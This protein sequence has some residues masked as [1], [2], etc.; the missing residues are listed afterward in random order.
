MK[1]IILNGT[2]AMVI[3][4]PLPAVERGGVLVRT[5]FSLISTGTEIASLLPPPPSQVSPSQKVQEAAGLALL[6]L[7]K[8]ARNPAKAAQRVGNILGRRVQRLIPRKPSEQSIQV[9]AVEWRRANAKALT[10]HGQGLCLHSDSS[11]FLYQAFST[12]LP[13]PEGCGVVV[14]LTG[15]LTGGPIALGLLAGTDGPWLGTITLDEGQLDERLAF[16]P[17]GQPSVTLVF[18]NAG[19]GRAVQLD[20][21]RIDITLPPP[22]AGPQSEMDQQGWAVGYSLVGEIIAVGEGVR[23]LVIGDM[24]AC[25]GANKANHAEYVAVKRNMACR[26]P[27]GCDPRWA[28]TTTVGAIALQGVRRATPQIGERIAVIGLGLIG[29]LCAQMLR[30]AGSVVIGMDLDP[31][32]IS[33]AKALGLDAGTSDPD[34]FRQIIRDLTGGLGVDRVLVAAATKSN[35]VLNLAMEV[36]RSKGTIVIVGDIGLAVDR[37]HFYRKE[38][39]LLMSTSY[40]PGRY[41]PAYEEDGIDYPAPYVRWTMN[42]N[43]A[44]YMDL[45]S[46]NRI[47]VEPLIDSEA[48]ISQAPELYKSLVEG[49]QRPLGV[50]ISYPASSETARAAVITLKGAR[51]SKADQIN[52]VLVGAGAFGISMLVP[53]LARQPD[54]FCLRGIVSADAVRGGNFARANRLEIVASDL[55]QTLEDPSIHCAIIA[56]R[57]DRHAAQVITALEAGR[58]VF[59]EKPLALTWQELDAVVQA[60]AKAEHPPVVMVGFNRRFSPAVQR[61]K[62]ELAERR[63][64]LMI[65]YRVNAGYIPKDNWVQGREGG[66]RNLGE[67]CHM[68]DVFRCLTGAPVTSIHATAIAPDA[69]AYL[70]TDNFTATLAYED[71]SVCT[72]TY[73][74]LGPKTGLPK[75]RVEVYCDGKA[76]VID[77]F[78]TLWAAGTDSPLWQSEEADKGHAEEIARFGDAIATGSDAPISFDEIVEVTA[79]ALEIEEV[80]KHGA[81]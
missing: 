47:T 70:R 63:S 53:L 8:A 48:S 80:L 44:S 67:A 60:R 74:A 51:K 6:Y 77:D 43:M 40:G 14:E 72:L 75:E 19:C 49:E 41:D 65:N 18:T 71:G 58:H 7:G 46:Q 5:H 59:V 78:K 2:G 13:I 24:V 4:S 3:R 38:I 12:T 26:V 39:N 30:A 9:G 79:V 36:A 69:G 11:L 34:Q 20:L 15:T 27:R 1:Q 81:P 50:L 25:C 61:I 45:I 66:G 31:A 22:E 42:R 76:F 29:Q 33:R 37:A 56:T 17:V 35:A 21:D 57:H 64:P 16:D 68:Y 52:Y 28:A 55:A 62:H 73:T 54:R 32:R 10:T 23:D